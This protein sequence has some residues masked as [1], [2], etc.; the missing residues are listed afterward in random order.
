MTR[1]QTGL[2][3]DGNLLADFRSLCKTEGYGLGGAVEEFMRSAVQGKSTKL[4]LAGANRVTEGQKN[5][6]ELSL[7]AKI[8][9]VESLVAAGRI[10]FQKSNPI[11][12]V[13]NESAVMR[14]IG[15]ILGI[16]ARIEEPSLRNHASAAVEGAMKYVEEER[17]FNARRRAIFS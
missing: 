3:V 12:G 1:V 17:L 14:S 10:E 2:R 11:S 5:A 6:D 9:D 16:L 13:N 7:R 8:V 4:A 15:S